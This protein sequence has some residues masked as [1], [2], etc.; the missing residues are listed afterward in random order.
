MKTKYRILAAAFI[1][2]LMVL[3][4]LSASSVSAAGNGHPAAEGTPPPP[5]P[6]PDPGTP[7]PSVGDND[8][9]GERKSII[10]QIF[11]IVF[12]YRTMKDAIISTINGM[13][14]DAVGDISTTGSPLYDVGSEISEI[15]FQTEKLKELRLSTWVGLRKVAFALLPLVAA[16]TIW[17][18]MKDGL[19]SV[20]GY[21][22]TL[23]AVTEFIVSIAIALASY[24]IMEQLISLT[25]SLTLAIAGAF[26]INITGS[27]FVGSLLKSA[28]FSTLS[29]LMS[30]IFS[31]F[32]FVFLVVFMISVELAFLAREVVLIITVGMAPL[33]IV[34][35]SVR[36]LG[37]LRALW[38][39][40]FVVFLLILPLNV[41]LL[42][43]AVKLHI[44]AVDLSSG[45]LSTV[46]QLLILAGT[47]SIL[48]ALNTT[49]GK[50]VYGAAIEVAKQVGSTLLSLGTMAAG[51]AVG[52]GALG[53]GGLAAAGGSMGGSQPLMPVSGG[54]GS[55]GADIT[56]T[57]RLT[58]TIGGVLSS[59]GNSAVRN[60]G[61]G[62][63]S[64]NAIRDHRLA[65]Q[66]PPSS[67]PLD[68]ANNGMP[69]YEAGIADVM[70][71]FENNPNAVAAIGSDE[72]IL[73]E[74]T[75]LGADTAVANLRAMESA[76]LSARDG[77]RETSYLHAG[78]TNIE[79][80]GREFIRAE[81]GSFALGD[82]SRYQPNEIT[83]QV[84]PTGN[85]HPRDFAVGHRIVQ[86]EQK[87]HGSSFRNITPD[88]MESVARAVHARR[89]SGMSSNLDIIDS[90]AKNN[91]Q[92][93]INDSLGL[94]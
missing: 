42:G 56:S 5:S 22:N 2:L 49:L 6:P 14:E 18:S 11:N 28:S 72:Q 36:P 87:H 63:R 82:S 29:P 73:T 30:M 40:S 88:K 17:A 37:W 71:Q 41:L 62:L 74:N 1:L 27:V 54:G 16:M 75:R 68:I 34:L 43:I 66:V 93:W 67:A 15:V 33:M 7:E 23:E 26:E 24:W 76:G 61:R 45:I 78:R 58:S 13:F 46:L 25:K 4:T 80:A 10:G 84:P 94:S 81:A 8:E 9:G 55:G 39:K 20:T 77:L 85:L 48:I 47:I 83:A 90:A 57:S 51:L 92:D 12:D 3:T 65:N 91:L 70:D 86:A 64:G 32:A 19:Y 53:A 50:L 31:I 59:S 60:L 35:G 52:A 44:S 69:G 21:A 38:S 79:M 89:L